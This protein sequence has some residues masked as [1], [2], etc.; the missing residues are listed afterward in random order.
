VARDK[1]V[2]HNSI[3]CTRTVRVVDDTPSLELIGTSRY[4][5][6]QFCLARV[7]L[8]KDVTPLARCNLRSILAESI[9]KD[10]TDLLRFRTQS[11]YH[12]RDP[13][14][15]LRPRKIRSR[16][17]QLSERQLVWLR[18][19]RERL[20]SELAT[21]ASSIAATSTPPTPSA[22][23]VVPQTHLQAS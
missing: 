16:R 18:H 20:C 22:R 15:T 5:S 23:I 8:P 9:T 17:L 11:T 21:S 4:P 3:H 12:P 19:A 13:A 10:S 2:F 6:L 7:Q 14:F 1:L